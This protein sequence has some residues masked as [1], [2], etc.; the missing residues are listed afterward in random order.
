MV[1][2]LLHWLR[3]RSSSSN[4]KQLLPSDTAAASTPKKS[5]GS[6][7]EIR[8]LKFTD[9]EKDRIGMNNP[10]ILTGYRTRV[11]FFGCLKSLFIL[12]NETV[13]IWS[14]L[15]GFLFFAGLF[16]HDLVL[17][18]PAVTEDGTQITKTDFA[19]LSTLLICY[20]ATMVLSS[21]YHTFEC[22]S[23][24]EVSSA[25]FALDIL[26]ITLGLM[27]TYLS[28]I[29]YAFWCEP[30]WRDF[31]LLTVGGIFLV[32]TSTHFVPAHYRNSEQFHNTRTA[33]FT[34]WAIYGIVPTVHWA[35]MQGG[36]VVVNLMVP[37]I[38]FMYVL[39]GL[40]MFF[41]VTKMPER[42]MPGFV[43][44]IGH[45]HQWWHVIIFLALIFWH[46]TGLTFA[47]FRLK[48]GCADSDMIDAKDIEEL[49]INFWPF[50][51]F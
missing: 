14:H 20:Q 19:I 44:I 17:I 39:C 50:S 11:G 25:C 42:L 46:Q 31:Y 35:W 2:S 15:I 18:I 37:R 29:Y 45:S 40:A 36:G 3:P 6:E 30:G 13:N 12:H 34:L 48:H 38:L 22:H 1:K 41:Y 27:A 51:S 5:G 49:A 23:S 8:L 4:T 26:G 24:T 10:F 16:L 28:G 32:A 7:N 33:L 47:L 21:L 9:I 43:D